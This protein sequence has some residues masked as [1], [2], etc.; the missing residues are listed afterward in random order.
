[1]F[2]S[3]SRLMPD[4]FSNH[5]ASTIA[6]RTADVRTV[7]ETRKGGI[8]SDETVETSLVNIAHA[9]VSSKKRDAETID[10]LFALFSSFFSPFDTFL[11]FLFRR[12]RTRRSKDWRLASANRAFTGH[13]IDIAS[14]EQFNERIASP[15]R[16]T[17]TEAR[18]HSARISVAFFFFFLSKGTVELARS[19]SRSLRAA[20][21]RRRRG[22]IATISSTVHPIWA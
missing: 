15:R 16:R 1:M 20:L 2:C 3:F 18:R 17:R 12:E 4:L 10:S 7:A 8:S 5:R 19:R 21:P 9:R 22:N 14:D 13:R 6:G 11:Y